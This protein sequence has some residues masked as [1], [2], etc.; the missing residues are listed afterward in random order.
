VF[1]F[2]DAEDIVAGSIAIVSDFLLETKGFICSDTLECACS[3]FF[4]ILPV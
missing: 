4:I 2:L 1:L 3:T